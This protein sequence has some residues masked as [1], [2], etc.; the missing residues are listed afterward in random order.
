M[1]G[2]S[3]ASDFAKILLV[4][5]LSNSNIRDLIRSAEEVGVP[6]EVVSS[7]VNIQRGI[8]GKGLVVY[9]GYHGVLVEDIIQNRREYYR[10]CEELKMVL[11]LYIVE[12]RSA[13][14]TGDKVDIFNIY[15]LLKSLN[16]YMSRADKEIELRFEKYI[17]Y[18][19]LNM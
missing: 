15:R 11:V 3:S 2:S 12:Y 14:L 18:V 16:R 1:F 17:E 19:R 6:L 10:K 7:L 13:K 5:E 9:R 8:L 4:E